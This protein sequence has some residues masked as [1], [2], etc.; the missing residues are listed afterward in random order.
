MEKN[1]IFY[2]PQV[3]GAHCIIG[4]KKYLDSSIILLFNDDEFSQCYGQIKKASEALTK[5]DILQPYISDQDFR[6]SND[7]KIVGY[8]LY[9]FEE[10]NEK[11]FLAAQPIKAESEFDGVVAGDINVYALVLTIKIISLSSDEQH[12]IDPIRS[13][14]FEALGTIYFFII[15]IIIIYYYLPTF[16]TTL[17]I[18]FIVNF[19]FFSKA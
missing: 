19:V 5:D 8:N 6:S 9:V 14:C 12:H 18:F 7:G 2:R 1:E 16:F 4:M 3:T 10:R 11:S 17:L 13:L 15:I